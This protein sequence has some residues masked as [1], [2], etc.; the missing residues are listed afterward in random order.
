MTTGLKADSSVTTEGCLGRLHASVPQFGLNKSVPIEI[1][2]TTRTRGDGLAISLDLISKGETKDKAIGSYKLDIFETPKDHSPYQVDLSMVDFLTGEGKEVT[3]YLTGVRPV[4]SGF[5]NIK[6]NI[7]AVS[8]Q[9]MPSTLSASHAR[10]LIWKCA[11]ALLIDLNENIAVK[12]ATESTSDR[13]S[14]TLNTAQSL[15]LICQAAAD[16]HQERAMG[17]VE[18]LLIK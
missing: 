12:A 14:Q 11:T 4:K 17:Q 2:Y 18:R 8:S 10:M 9:D 16:S 1:S 13:N 3:T 6:D 5:F 7:E 15:A